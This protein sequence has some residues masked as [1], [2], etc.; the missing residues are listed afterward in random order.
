MDNLKPTELTGKSVLLLLM[1]TP[2]QGNVK[3]R[4]AIDIG[5][6]CATE[7]YRK[8][9]AEVVKE[10]GPGNRAYEQWFYTSGYFD[11]LSYTQWLGECQGYLKQPKGDLGY[12]LY[13]GFK[14]CFDSGASRVIA[15]GTDCMEV[16]SDDIEK[17]LVK[18][19]SHDSV[20][21]PAD[22][23]GY[24][25]LGFSKEGFNKTG[26][27]FESLFKD[28]TWSSSSVFEQTLDKLSGEGLSCYPLI[29]KRDIDTLCDLNASV[30]A[31]SILE[32][33][34]NRRKRF[35]S[36]VL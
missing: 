2:E 24:Y 31:T 4:L 21:G 33:I 17:S 16:T 32:S 19:R 35:A 26:N 18:L 30:K 12:K 25:L 23:G 14:S 10:T 13:Y 6:E 3:T 11:K 9:V 15:I 34:K 20:I 1:K 8:M 27:R 29:E 5:E 36:D 28:I 22:D 7:F